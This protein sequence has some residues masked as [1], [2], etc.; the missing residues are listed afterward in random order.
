MA[1]QRGNYGDGKI[2]DGKNVAKGE[3]QGLS[4]SVARVNSPISKLE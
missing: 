2:R 4:L 1:N 3:G